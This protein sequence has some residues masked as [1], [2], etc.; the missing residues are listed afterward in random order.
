MLARLEMGVCGLG[1][2]LIFLPSSDLDLECI[3][4]NTKM[5]IDIVDQVWLACVIGGLCGNCVIIC[6]VTK[7]YLAHTWLSYPM[8]MRR[9]LNFVLQMVGA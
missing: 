9:Y 7:V 2:C 8:Y 4:I 5:I 3:K 6:L 1:N